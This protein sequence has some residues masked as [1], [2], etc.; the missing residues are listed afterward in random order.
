MVS[1][2]DAFRKWGFSEKIQ[3]LEIELHIILFKKS[4]KLIFQDLELISSSVV[5]S[6]KRGQYGVFYSAADLQALKRSYGGNSRSYLRHD[7]RICSE[8]VREGR[9]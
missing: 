6:S 9:E 2:K 1:R 5:M 3:H 4:E 8:K 7:S